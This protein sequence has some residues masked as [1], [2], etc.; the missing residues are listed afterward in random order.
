M[1]GD[2]FERSTIL[3]APYGASGPKACEHQSRHQEKYH[4]GAGIRRRGEEDSE[5]AQNE[6]GSSCLEGV[7]RSFVRRSFKAKPVWCGGIVP[8]ASR[9]GHETVQKIN[10][11]SGRA[12]HT[13][14]PIQKRKSFRVSEIASANTRW[15]VVFTTIPTSQR[16][17]LAPHRVATREESQV[18]P[19]R[20]DRASATC[21]VPPR[22]LFDF[23]RRGTPER[24]REMY[25]ASH[26]RNS[27]RGSCG[28]VF[29]KSIRDLIIHRRRSPNPGFP[30]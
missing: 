30:Q 12:I 6:Q 18:H 23:Q 17:P 22:R 26:G 4:Y 8:M 29:A 13:L 5:R 2:G 3:R 25:R 27:A 21:R 20:V 1:F 9:P 14:I 16:G 10:A 15:V 24:G 19:A 11:S 28:T 7:P